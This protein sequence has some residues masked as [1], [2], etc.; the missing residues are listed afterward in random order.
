MDSYSKPM[1]YQLQVR[2]AFG[3]TN[4][5]DRVNKFA[6]DGKLG[7]SVAMLRKIKNLPGFY[8][9]YSGNFYHSPIKVTWI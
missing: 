2:H 8:K 3:H 4:T 9:K 1:D 7:D 6:R 5:K